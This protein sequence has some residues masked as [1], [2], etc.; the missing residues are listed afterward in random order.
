MGAKLIA[1]QCIAAAHQPSLLHPDKLTIHNS[2]WAFCPF[3]ARAT[4]HE[5]TDTGGIE[6]EKLMSHVGLTRG[7]AAGIAKADASTS[8]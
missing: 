7:V 3:D 5:W 8:W 1:Y 4:D 6:F 2:H